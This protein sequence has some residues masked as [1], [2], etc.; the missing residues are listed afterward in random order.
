MVFYNEKII[1][2][3]EINKALYIFR[4]ITNEIIMYSILVD[5]TELDEKTLVTDSVGDFDVAF[6]HNDIFLI[7]SNDKRELKLVSIKDNK[8]ELISSDL[9]NTIYELNLIIN[10]NK[11]YIFYIEGSEE[12]EN[13]YN[14]K[15]IIYNEGNEDNFIVDKIATYNFISPLKVI[16]ENN[17]ICIAYYFKNQICFKEFN[18]VNGIWSPSFTLT[19]NRNKLYL[20]MI[21]ISNNLH[22]VYSEYKDENFSTKYEKFYIKRGNII[23]EKEEELTGYGNHTDPILIYHLNKLW[24]VWKGTNQF[25][26]RVSEDNGDSFSEVYTWKESNT[27]DL[28]KYKYITNTVEKGIKIDYS[29]GSY[30]PEIK[31]IGFGKSD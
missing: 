2:A 1:I 29:Y 20:D 30:H 3:E 22:L 10:N 23:K 14:V 12:G 24:V 8:T 28:V 19:D 21:L 7:Y 13:I 6:N 17:S 31:F 16:L 9:N 27:V 18:T 4:Q 11:K 5:G 25:M 26:S 15:Q